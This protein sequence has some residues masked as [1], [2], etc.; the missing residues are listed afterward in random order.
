MEF[1]NDFVAA[2]ETLQ[3]SPLMSSV[4]DVQQIVMMEEYIW[5]IYGEQLVELQTAKSKKTIVSERNYFK[6]RAL[7]KV[8]F[9]LLM[10][11]RPAASSAAFGILIRD[12]AVPIDGR[13]SVIIDEVGYKGNAIGF[14]RFTNADYSG[15]FTFDN[16]LYDTVEMLTVKVALHFSPSA[17]Q[18]N[19]MI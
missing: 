13:W 4:C 16:S 6:S 11:R 9:E 12:T 1:S 3:L 15:K 18:H 19:N 14:S 8:S 5:L 2:K 17:S 10:A 7:E